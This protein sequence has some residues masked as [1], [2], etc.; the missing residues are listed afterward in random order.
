MDRK[1]DDANPNTG[2]FQFSR[3]QGN[4]AAAPTDGNATAPACTSATDATGVWNSINGSTNCGGAS[5][6]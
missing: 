2:A 5:L 3:F 6:L 4:A 1:I